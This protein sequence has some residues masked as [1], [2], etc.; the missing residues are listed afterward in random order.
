MSDTK[1]ALISGTKW[2]TLSTLITNAVGIIKLSILTRLL[3]KSEF[4]LMAILSM[5]LEV[6]VTF[7]N[8]GFATAIMHKQDLTHKEFC[9]LYW[10]QFIVF[11]FCYLIIVSVAYPISLFY[12]EPQL[13]YM[14]PLAGLGIIFNSVG[15]FYSTVFQKNMN[16][17]FLSTRN[18]IASLFSLIIAVVLAFNGFGVLSLVL[19]DLLN[20][21]IFNIWNFIYG[22]KYFKMRFFVSFKLVKPLVKIG[23]YQTG[24]QFLDLL[25]SRID[26]FIISKFLGTE[27]L[28][29]YNIAKSLVLKVVTIIN[30]ITN[31]VS[32]PYFSKIQGDESLLRKN[33][34]KVLNLL[35]HIDFPIC[36]VI[37]SMSC[38]IVPVLYGE[39]YNDIIP[40]VSILSIWSMLCCVGNPVGNIIKATGQTKQ[41]FK[42]TIIRMFIVFPCVL[43]SSQYGMIWVAVFQIIS[44]VIASFVLWHIELWQTIRLKLKDYINSFIIKFIIG[45]IIGGLVFS[46]SFFLKDYID[47]IIYSALI[48]GFLLVSLYVIVYAVFYKDMLMQLKAYVSSKIKRK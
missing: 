29:M 18:I 2:T 23:L 16:F 14:L 44:S 7:S 43:I 27:I 33:Y 26:I 21:L 3:E 19:S 45:L 42:Y 4:G 17:K 11:G 10:I 5:V 9:S 41:S 35:S 37:G 36:V 48:S 31:T 13:L 24:T 40:V 8:L 38:F 47:N 1:Q 25:S 30:G 6:V 39:S 46:I 22:Q 32:L 20:A 12:E 15:N 34:L 28:G